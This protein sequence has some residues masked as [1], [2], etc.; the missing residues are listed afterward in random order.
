MA[1]SDVQYIYVYTDVFN[2]EFQLNRSTNVITIIATH[3]TDFFE[4][5]YTGY[6]D[7]PQP[8]TPNII[9]A[10]MDDYICY[11]L[12]DNTKITFPTTYN[13]VND[14]LIMEIVYTE[15]YYSYVAEKKIIIVLRSKPVTLHKI[16]ESKIVDICDDIK[17]QINYPEMP[18]IFD[19]C[20][21]VMK[22]AQCYVKSCTDII[23]KL[24]V[25]LEHLRMTDRIPNILK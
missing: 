15:K 3:N 6:N 11:Q 8:F 9:F 21:E 14:P 24:Q 22:I 12:D 2:Y 18:S 13:A 7:M 17:N 19:K 23:E 25:E 5:I 4:W 16:F 10:I 1:H 20:D